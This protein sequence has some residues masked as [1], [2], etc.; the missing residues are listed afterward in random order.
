M[1]F[2]SE[3]DIT[4]CETLD[5]LKIVFTQ[6]YKECSSDPEALKQIN[7]MKEMRKSQLLESEDLNG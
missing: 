4:L 3:Q 2:R 7:Y 1:L 5:E 6:A